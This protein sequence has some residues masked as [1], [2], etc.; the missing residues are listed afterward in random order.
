MDDNFDN[1]T[2]AV[3]EE[4]FKDGDILWFTPDNYQTHRIIN[5]DENSSTAISLQATVYS[6][7]QYGYAQAFDYGLLNICVFTNFK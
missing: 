1:A 3:K 2:K 4:S 5:N 6:G 7:S